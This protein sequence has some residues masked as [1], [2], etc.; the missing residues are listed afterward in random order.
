MKPI[1]SRLLIAAAAVLLG[2]ALSQSQTASDTPPPP[3][4]GHEFGMHGPMGEFFSR[5]LDLTDA[6]KEQMK[7]VLQ[8]E[9]PTVRP[10]MEQSRAMEQQLRQYAEGNYD[11]KKV[12][13]LATQKAQVDAQLAIQRTRIES[14][15]YQ[16]LTP[17][18]Q[19]KVK[20]LEAQHAARFRTGDRQT[21]PPP[22]EDQ[23]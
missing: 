17:D 23:Q 4:H 20:E 9:H 6:Q 21:P 7:A 11:E 1:F 14:E 18:Q 15:L 16:L 8:K 19:A 5:Q 3:M 10:L 2:T 22:P 13:A 12:S